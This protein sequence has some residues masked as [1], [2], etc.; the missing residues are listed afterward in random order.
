MN[1]S[2]STELKNL[3]A[4][5]QLAE[6]FDELYLLITNKEQ[7]D[8]L[9][10]LK[11][12]TN[13]LSRQVRL[14]LID[15][16]TSTLERNKIIY[17]LLELINYLEDKSAPSPKPPVKEPE[18]RLALVIG[19]DNYEY[20]N[21]LANPINDVHLMRLKLDALGF[22]VIVREN[23][24]L[25]ELKMSIDDF[26]QELSNYDVGLFYF[27]GHGIQ[28][29]GLNY[30]VPVDAN[31]LE[32]RFVEYDCVRADRVI[33]YMEQHSGQEQPKVNIVILD[34]CRN[35]PFERGWSRSVTARG[36]ATMDAPKGTFIAYATAPGS[37]A[38]DGID[39]NGLYTESLAKHIDA[40]NVPIGQL[41]QQV[42]KE[43]LQKSS[44]KQMPWEATSL[45][46]D[47]YFI[48]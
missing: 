42:R 4:N 15:Y 19:C 32:E 37:T 47:F 6:A 16:A 31:I 3:I 17:A 44:N 26:G 30:L 48:Q 45:I 10:L 35:N 34:A 46:G 12:K 40:V 22:K 41:F 21:R 43:V 23:P 7:E 11:S 28:V 20:A 24:T 13:D 39:R 8:E 2:K 33:A 25:K 27:A 5:N 9:I 36:L 29:S 1:T 38:S 14:G 18:K